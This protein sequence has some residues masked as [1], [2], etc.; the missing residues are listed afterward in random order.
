MAKVSFA[1]LGLKPNATI[2]TISYNEQDIEVKQYLSI[3][4]KLRIIA[5]VLN[6][7]VDEYNFANPVKI[8]I[9]TALEIMYAYTNI[10]FTDKQKADP[11]KLY[12]LLDGAGLLAEVIAAIPQTEFNTVVSGVNKTIEAYHTY[13]NSLV[14]IL[15]AVTT[16]YSNLDLDAEAIKN[17]IGDP[18]NLELLRAVLTK[19]G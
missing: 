7:S 5:T 4:E 16:D 8:E 18:Q 15:E 14:G 3:N 1:K 11:A 2:K 9:L 13:K 17:K 6:E 19:L 10:N 12:D